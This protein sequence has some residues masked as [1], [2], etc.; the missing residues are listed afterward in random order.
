MYIQYLH[1]IHLPTTFPYSL[2]LPLVPMLQTGPVL[3][4]CTLSLWKKWPFC[5]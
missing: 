2:P 4:S 1:H 5:L 3:L